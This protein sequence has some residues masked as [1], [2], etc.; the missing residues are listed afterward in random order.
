[1]V[2]GISSPE[3]ASDFYP[4][5]TMSVRPFL[6]EFTTLLAIF[7][8]L[9]SFGTLLTQETSLRLGTIHKFALDFKS[10]ARFKYRDLDGEFVPNFI[11]VFCHNSK[12]DRVPTHDLRAVLLDEE[13]ADPTYK[14]FHAGDGQESPI[15]VV[16][17]WTWNGKDST[18]SF[19]LTQNIVDDM[20]AHADDWDAYIWRS[21]TW[22][23]ALRP[24]PLKEGSCARV[25]SWC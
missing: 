5:R 19:W 2:S 24:L 22:T 1:M 6:A 8:R 16:S 14:V 12:L 15:H 7:R 3:R 9:L 10:D 18:A 13:D 23:Q 25:Q 4:N 17:T 20:L 11:H 21:E